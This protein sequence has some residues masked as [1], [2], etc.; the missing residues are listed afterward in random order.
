MSEILKVPKGTKQN[1]ELNNHKT[2]DKKGPANANPLYEIKYNSDGTSE[3]TI[4]PPPVIYAD[5]V[6]SQV[7]RKRDGTYVDVD[8][9]SGLY[10]LVQNTGLV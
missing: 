9:E 2:A 7:W 8:T 5:N 10:G 3:Y 6:G 1:G 4:P